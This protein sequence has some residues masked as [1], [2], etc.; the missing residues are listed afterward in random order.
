MNAK[1]V[2]FVEAG[3]VKS[4]RFPLRRLM[5]NVKNLNRRVAE[6]CNERAVNGS[7]E[8][9]PSAFENFVFLW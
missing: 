6:I 7:L 3:S 2:S 8:A 9:E 1:A 4:Y 5:S